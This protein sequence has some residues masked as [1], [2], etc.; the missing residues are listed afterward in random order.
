M[1]KSNSMGAMNLDDFEAHVIKYRGS[2]IS[3]YVSFREAA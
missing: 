2:K 1:V 3:R